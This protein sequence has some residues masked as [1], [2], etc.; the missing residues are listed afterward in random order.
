MYQG[1][2]V[3]RFIILL[4]FFVLF[5]NGATLQLNTLTFKERIAAEEL[6]KSDLKNKDHY[7][8]LNKEEKLH[9]LNVLKF[10]Y[11][12]TEYE[13]VVFS[14]RLRFETEEVE[15]ED[16]LSQLKEGPLSAELDPN[17]FITVSISPFK[18]DELTLPFL[19]TDTFV[20]LDS[21]IG[22]NEDLYLE[23]LDIV[24][25]SNLDP[26]GYTWNFHSWVNIIDEEQELNYK[27][28]IGDAFS[29]KDYTLYFFLDLRANS[30]LNYT[31]QPET[32]IG[33]KNGRFNNFLNYALEDFDLKKEIRY[34]S[35]YT[36]NK[37][38]YI[39]YEFKYVEKDDSY[40]NLVGV[41]VIF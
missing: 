35:E 26:Y 41:R 7:K 11:S 38:S 8:K 24:K 15:N 37:N 20:V 9:V 6:L 14:E 29:Y 30:T 32:A 16:Y 18:K 34:T 36:V 22:F 39:T 31:I 23:K 40:N 3:V 28:G 5:L 10:K 1:V 13:N 33:F 21:K 25:I 12:N 19:N 4:S 2:F 27:I 17:T